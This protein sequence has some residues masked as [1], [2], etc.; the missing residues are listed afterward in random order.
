MSNRQKFVAFFIHCSQIFLNEKRFELTIIVRRFVLFEIPCKNWIFF[1]LFD[2]LKEGNCVSNNKNS[3]K[4]LG[5]QIYRTYSKLCQFPFWTKQIYA[6][7]M[8]RNN[9]TNIESLFQGHGGSVG[10]AHGYQ[11]DGHGFES[12]MR[13]IWSKASA[14]FES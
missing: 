2:M 11:S 4:S 13:L 14:S 12:W 10:W 5:Y 6:N 1:V 7:K 8:A 3:Q 9:L